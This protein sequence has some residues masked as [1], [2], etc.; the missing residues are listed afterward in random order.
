MN[1][2][3]LLRNCEKGYRI[4]Y[5]PGPGRLYSG[6]IGVGKTKRKALV[7]CLA[8][9]KNH[10]DGVYYVRRSLSTKARL[11]DPYEG[12]RFVVEDG[13]VT[14]N[15][16]TFLNFDRMWRVIEIGR[17]FCEIWEVFKPLVL[18]L[19]KSLGQLF[20]ACF[21]RSKQRQRAMYNFDVGS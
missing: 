7:E 5:K 14:N 17:I 20:A 9:F 10:G 19:L 11:V 13:K 18:E 8:N 3:A 6:L 2:L 16:R 21:A 15:D 4:C 1:I 12:T